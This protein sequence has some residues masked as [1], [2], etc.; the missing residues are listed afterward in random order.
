MKNFIYLSLI[1]V[2]SFQVVPLVAGD[3][4]APFDLP[5]AKVLPSGVRNFTYKGAFIDGN[6]KFNN[7]GENKRLSAPLNEKITFQ[8]LLDSKKEYID[9]AGIRQ[10]M[11][12][13]HA[14]ESDQ[15]GKTTGELSIAAMANV[16]VFAYGITKKMTLALAVPIVQSSVAI[17]VGVIHTN[18]NKII[19]FRDKITQG[20]GASNK[21]AEFDRKMRNPTPSKLEEYGYSPLANESKTQLGDIKLV[22]KYNV[23]SNRSHLFTLQGDL[24]LPTGK[25]ADV[26]KVV[27][28]AGGDGQTDVGVGL[29]HDYKLGKYFT[30]S[31]L[32]SYT[33]QLPDKTAKRIPEDN[34]NS[35]TPD[36]D[37]EVDRDLGDHMIAS[38]AGKFNYYG[39]NLGSSYSVLY[40]EK[41]KYSGSK[42]DLERYGWLEKNTT[43]NMQAFQLSI[44]YDTI[45]LFQRKK[46]ALPLS[47]CINHT[48][49]LRGKNVISDPL[50]SLDFSMFF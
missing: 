19:S 32:A 10:A 38:I 8:T 46:F 36:V 22:S 12:A 45:D 20:Y 50:T 27:D 43:Q 15:L 25:E 31:S 14:K 39:F 48:R 41:D 29:L 1:V 5:S 6:K 44:G 30:I 23:F 4:Q 17:D 40:K 7:H 26:N 3:L 9:K 35:L 24:T 49:I 33:V 34:D 21:G 42:F 47:F 2:M 16:P 37:M 11:I 13:I 28:I 18:S